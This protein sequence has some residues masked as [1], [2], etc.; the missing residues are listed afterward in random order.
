MRSDRMSR[1]FCAIALPLLFAV[2]AGC[3]TDPPPVPTVDGGP[4]AGQVVRDAGEGMDAS[5]PDGGGDADTP[6]ADL[7]DT[8]TADAGPDAPLDGAPFFPD[9]A[10]GAL[11]GAPADGGFTPPPPDSGPCTDPDGGRLLCSCPLSPA[12][13]V[14]DTCA[15]NQICTVDPGCGGM[16]CDLRG[17]SCE[18]DGDCPGASECTRGGAYRVCVPPSTT[19]AD[20]RDCPSGYSCESGACVAR[21]VPCATA[22]QCPEGY[23]CNTSRAPGSPFC[24]PIGR[25]CETDTGCNAPF[26]CRDLDG[27]GETECGGA[28]PCPACSAGE[29]CGT[30]RLSDLVCS[31]FGPCTD[32]SQCASSHECVDLGIG[33]KNCVARGGSCTT[34][35]DC[36]VGAICA[37]PSAAD[38]PRCIDAP[39]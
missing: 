39:L 27:D 19:C 11:D 38:S 4:D 37:V 25:R 17:L 14:D 16:R 33:I 28:G 23:D 31:L 34:Q 29:R 35:A 8:G 32:D 6:D 10:P 30:D 13:T 9:G 2:P 12:C 15:T 20:H 3:D 24:V 18:T 22:E 26:L 5:L 7:V 1:G 36:P 21:R